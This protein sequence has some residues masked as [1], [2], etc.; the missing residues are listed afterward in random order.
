LRQNGRHQR[1][2]RAVGAGRATQGQDRDS[3]S[4][5]VNEA[6][7]EREIRQAGK[8]ARSCEIRAFEHDHD[9]AVGLGEA[10]GEVAVICIP[11]AIG[12]EGVLQTV[13]EIQPCGAEQRG[14]IGRKQH[15]PRRGQKRSDPP[16]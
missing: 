12:D 4:D 11:R 1:I 16:A 2:G 14:K 6:G 3:G 15:Q 5:T 7:L 8:R 13:V 10:R 9:I